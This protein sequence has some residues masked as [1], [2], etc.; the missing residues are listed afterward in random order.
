MNFTDIIEKYQRIAIVG[1]NKN[2][3]KTVALNQFID[4]A[5]SKGKIIGATSIGRDGERK[6][7]VTNTEKPPIFVPKGTLIATA[8][9]CA[10]SCE[11]LLEIIDVTTLQTAIGRV[12]ICRAKEAGYVEIAGPDSSSEIKKVCDIMQEHGAELILIDGALNRKTQASPALA[13][14][15]VLSTG[16]VLGRSI[17]VVLNKTIHTV[18]MLTL[19]RVEAEDLRICGEAATLSYVS[20][21]DKE[22]NIINTH[23]KTALGS[24]HKIMDLVKADYE[25]IVIPGT[26]MNS[27]IKA[28]HSVL[29]NNKIKLVVQDGTKIFVEPMDYRIFEKLGGRIK[30]IDPINL[31]AVTI[32]PYAPEGYNFEPAFFYD[33]MKEA[34]SPLDVFDCIQ[35]GGF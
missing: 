14:G 17:D 10:K 11:A 3:G 19:P 20:F 26:V 12:V 25:Y 34:L 22:K 24:A 28:M 29:R 31:L 4:I 13:D 2:A 23:Y 32:N 15:V 16:A 7:I 35:E 9:T 8:E 21:I 30:V 6:D 1:T 18:E 5:A 33:V 27:F